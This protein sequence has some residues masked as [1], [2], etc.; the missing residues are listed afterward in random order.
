[1]SNVIKPSHYVPVEQLRLL[2]AVR[3]HQQLQQE[4]TAAAKTEEEWDAE[5][6]LAQD[7][8]LDHLRRTILDDAQTLAE[9]QVRHANAEAEQLIE[10]GQAQIE[11]WWNERRSEDDALRDEIRTEAQS[12]GYAEG[13]ER[14]EAAVEEVY[15]S[16]VSESAAI[17]EQAYQLKE[18][19]IQEAEPFVVSLSCIIAE[20]IMNEQVA[21]EPERIVNMIR[22]QLLRK[23]ESGTITLC[24]SAEHFNML[25]AAREELSLSIDSQAELQIIPDATVKDHGCVIRSALGSIDAKI[26]T[27]LA[28]IKKALLQVAHQQ[29][30]R[31]DN[32]I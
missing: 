18:Q 24:V 21:I 2:E 15:A 4:E 17:L 19:I 9:D 12:T 3:K 22:T 29:E 1:M 30:E 27:Q 5:R 13:Y 25:H 6:L 20:K 31:S 11:T 16:K 32:D 26:D 23:R 14:A 8:Q 10:Q 7:E 28:E